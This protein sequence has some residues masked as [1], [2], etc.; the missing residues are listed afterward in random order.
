MM[1]T[2]YPSR[3]GRNLT[4]CSKSA[5][6]DSNEN[7]LTHSIK[8]S[9]SIETFL[10]SNASTSARSYKRFITRLNTRK[11]SQPTIRNREPFISDSMPVANRNSMKSFCAKNRSTLTEEPGGP[12][13]NGTQWNPLDDKMASLSVEWRFN[14]IDNSESMIS[15]LSFTSPNKRKSMLSLARSRP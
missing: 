2:D 9:R 7:F 14:P 3:R 12:Y 6:F 13:S 4:I 8:R 1:E 10:R 11:P 5:K 15:A